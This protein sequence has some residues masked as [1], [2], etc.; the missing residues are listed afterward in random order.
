MIKGMHCVLLLICFSITGCL[1][2]SP[3]E[4]SHYYRLVAPD[5]PNR[6]IE[7]N[8]SEII[9]VGPVT[10]ADY[11]NRTSVTLVR[12][13]SEYDFSDLD[14]WA[15]KLDN[16]IQLALMKH[17]SQLEPDRVVVGYPWVSD[18]NPQ[19]Q[20]RIDIVRFD[21]KP[22]AQAK[23][24]GSWFLFDK[25]NRFLRGSHFTATTEAGADYA[26]SVVAMSKLL[27]NMADHIHQ[28]LP[29]YE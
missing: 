6:P 4:K 7:P 13:D 5:L 8:G 26:Q 10:L 3:S 24:Q 1:S 28:A 12:S 11:L 21:A 2:T 27:A 15:G 17:L 22:G 19:Y 20:L 25:N 18:I 16:E 14:M 9:M 29:T 23:L